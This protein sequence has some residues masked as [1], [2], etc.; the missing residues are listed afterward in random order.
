MT[1]PRVHVPLAGVKPSYLFIAAG[2]SCLVCIGALRSNNLQM[3]K[4]RDAVYAADKDNGDVSKALT[5]LQRYVTSHMNT[6]LTPGNN[7]VYPP[8]QLKYT[9]ERL[10]EANVA[11]TSNAQVYSDA[12]AYCEAQN[13]TDF[14]GR[15]RVPCIQEYVKTH[16]ATV[17][18]AIPDSLY[19]FD[20]LSPR[21][22][23][24]LAG[25]TSISTIA[26]L[27]MAVTLLV[28]RRLLTQ[29]QSR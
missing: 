7:S 4:L 19:K 14:S 15:N 17:P 29:R 10:Q 9:Y 11:S 27:V 6:D 18:T 28:A 25:W 20:F 26:L 23:P 5:E 16:G 3:V 21:W 12:Q 24:D 2:V 22:S 1:K 8:I 13:S